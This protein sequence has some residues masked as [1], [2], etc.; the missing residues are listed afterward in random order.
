MTAL[1]RDVEA[2]LPRALPGL[3]WVRSLSLVAVGAAMG[4]CFNMPS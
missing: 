2:S 1:P 3:G 4:Y